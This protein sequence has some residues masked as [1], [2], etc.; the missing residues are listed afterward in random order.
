MPERVSL[1]NS[2]V[3]Y[4]YVVI[5]TIFSMIMSRLERD[6]PSI[7][8]V[9]SFNFK[10]VV[11]CAGSPH[12]ILLAIMTFLHATVVSGL[13]LFL[14]SIVEQ[15]GFSHNT[16][17]LLSAGPFAAGFLG[18]YCSLKGGDF[19]GLRTVSSSDF[20]RCTLVGPLQ[21]KRY[22]SAPYHHGRHC[23][24]CSLSR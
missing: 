8:P 16:T 19:P 7:K 10:E 13:V 17:Q 12:V 24:F 9:D 21:I 18:D 2:Y 5:S 1:S 4:L 20:T 14:P 23:R 11:R 3:A 22:S 6:R 15:L